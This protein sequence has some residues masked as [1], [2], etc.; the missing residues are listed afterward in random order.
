MRIHMLLENLHVLPFYL[1]HPHASREVYIFKKGYAGLVLR[2]V[3][4]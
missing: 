3:V 2:L 1:S 4:Y